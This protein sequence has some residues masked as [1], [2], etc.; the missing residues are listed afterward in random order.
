[1][2]IVLACDL[3]GTSFRAALVDDTGAIRAQHAIAGPASRDDASG[4]SEI[5]PDAWWDLLIEACSGLAAD[6]PALFEAVEAIA[7]CGVTRTQIFLNRDGRSLRPAMTWKDTRS[8]ALAARLR[9]KLDPAHQESAAINAFH[10]LARLAWLR[11]EEPE[12][13]GKLACLLEPKDYLN[14][15]LTG[16]QASDPVSMARLLAAAAPH[17]RHDLLEAAGIPAAILPGML[18]PWE[19][20]GPIQVDLP[21]QL[22]HLAGKPVFCA[23]N[24]TWAAV[25]GLGAMREGF[26][27]NISGTTEVLGVVG[28]EPARAE[29]LLTVDWRGL[30]QLGG[31]SQTGADTVSWLLALLGRDGA[32]VGQEIGALLA[33]QRQP[34]PLLFLPY[35]QGERVPYWDPSL[36]G[37]LIGLNRQ[38]GP[39]D[40]AFA[41]LE[42]VACLNRIVLERAEAALGRAA[43]EIRFGGGAA[44]NPVWSQIKADLC[45]RPV[46]VAASKEPGLLGAAIVAFAGLG[47]FASLAEAQQKLVTVARRFEPDPTRKP[48]Y[49][50]LFALFRQAEDALA[51]ISRDLVIAAQEG[52]PLAGLARHASATASLHAD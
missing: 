15:R 43:T 18:E 4:R 45:G 47:H 29:G 37:A 9:D 50:A 7:I 28:R 42:G 16:R 48:A 13:F 12:A 5:E 30:F 49:D 25:V 8:D 14:F 44:A 46:V 31:P 32:T 22:D 52:G 11:E 20:V 36:R 35:L 23:S 34:Q 33:G 39:T 38:H 2:S 19:Q 6:A 21:A 10:P 27:Y 1:M 51:P 17:G 3:G 26:A 40:L 41:V 24:D